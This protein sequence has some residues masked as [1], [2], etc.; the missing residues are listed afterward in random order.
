MCSGATVLADSGLLDGFRATT[1]W[2]QA[3]EFA[4]R[5]PKVR[6]EPDRIFVAD[7]PVW[8]SAGVTAGIDLALALVEQD[9]PIGWMAGVTLG[10]LDWF[11][12]YSGVIWCCVFMRTS[13]RRVR[14][15]EIEKPDDVESL[16]YHA[17]LLKRLIGDE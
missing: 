8:T 11:Y 2:S 12:V 6:L 17:S 16:F 14:F 3:S 7:G 15:G 9:M 5:Y 10:G 4:R 1:H 13:A